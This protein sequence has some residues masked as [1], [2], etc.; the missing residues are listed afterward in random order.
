MLTVAACAM[1][2]LSAVAYTITEG[3]IDAESVRVSGDAI[4]GALRENGQGKAAD[5][6]DCAT[7]VVRVIVKE[8]GEPP[9]KS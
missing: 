5:V 4:S 2:V 8:A 6:V 7:D 9:D 1:T 3:R